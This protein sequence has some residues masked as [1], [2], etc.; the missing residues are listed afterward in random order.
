MF[1]CYPRDV[2]L[3]DGRIVSI[4]PMN[5]EDGP[6]LLEFFRSLREEDR[7]FLRDDVVDPDL[8]NRWVEDLDYNKVVPLLGI[9]E[10]KIVA[11]ASIHRNKERWAQH[12]GQIR[13]VVHPDFQGS[14]LGYWMTREIFVVAHSM[15][16]EK[17][18]AEL[19]DPQV[20]AVN[21]FERLGFHKEHVFKNH[22][23]DIE[24]NYH[25]LIVMSVDINELMDQWVQAVRDSE[26]RGG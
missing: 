4:R 2:A 17:V 10:G 19:M 23:R 9:A 8:I 20:G 7:M 1:A 22:V 11:D 18:L 13:V 16:I 5:K 12:V 14:G 3:K 21:V 15:K 6:S 26:D 25:D 24:G